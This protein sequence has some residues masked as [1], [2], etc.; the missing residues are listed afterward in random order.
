M[1]MNLL[2]K[3]KVYHLMANAVMELAIV[4]LENAAVNMDGVVKLKSIVA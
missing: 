3:K 2:K 4:S 1:T